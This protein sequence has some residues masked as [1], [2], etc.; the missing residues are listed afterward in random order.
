[1]FGTT[2]GCLALQSTICRES[3]DVSHYDK[4]YI[5]KCLL[6]MVDVCHYDAQYVSNGGCLP[7]RSTISGESLDVSHNDTQFTMHNMSGKS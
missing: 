7:L 1:M 3:L 6:Q 4:H 2:G 5:G